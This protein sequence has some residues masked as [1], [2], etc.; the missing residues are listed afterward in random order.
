M[1]DP[2][3]RPRGPVDQVC[4]SCGQPCTAYEFNRHAGRCEFQPCGCIL[5]LEEMEAH[6]HT[7]SPHI[8]SY[9]D[10]W[11]DLGEFEDPR[12]ALAALRQATGQE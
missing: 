5:T 10:Y 1:I 4:V 11:Y 8:L 9:G 7:V 2:T 3:P 6:G 12:D